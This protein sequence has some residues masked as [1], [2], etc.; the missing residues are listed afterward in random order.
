M[1]VRIQGEGQ[2]DLEGDAIHQLKVADARLFDAVAGGAD[3]AFAREFAA[4]LTLV[5]EQGRRL[6]PTEL[7]ESDLVLPAGDTTLEEA[8]KLFTSHPT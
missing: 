3:E 4:V 1:I 5:R 8:R 6:G 7:R 2:Y